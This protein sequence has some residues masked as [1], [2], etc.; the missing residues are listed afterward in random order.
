MADVVGVVRVVLKLKCAA[1]TG[2]GIDATHVSWMGLYMEFLV[3]CSSRALFAPV[4]YS[5]RNV[6]VGLTFAI[7]HRIRSNSSH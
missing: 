4:T 1:P 7:E 3:T 5:A 6:I 2:A